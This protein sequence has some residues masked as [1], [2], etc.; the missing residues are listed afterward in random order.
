[1]N[2]ESLFLI[3][4][5]LCVKLEHCFSNSSPRAHL[6]SR[7]DLDEPASTVTFETFNYL[8]SVHTITSKS[9]TVYQ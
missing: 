9:L 1:M 8:L 2:S 5:Q 3:L 4:E 6:S 7:K